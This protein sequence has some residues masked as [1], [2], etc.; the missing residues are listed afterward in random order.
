LAEEAEVKKVVSRRAISSRLAA[1]IKSRRDPRRY[2][3]QDDGQRRVGA[4]RKLEA[5]PDRTKQ[6][7]RR[8]KLRPSVGMT[9]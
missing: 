1:Q 7:P 6:V 5:E 8:A 3:P 9:A 2:A 4:M